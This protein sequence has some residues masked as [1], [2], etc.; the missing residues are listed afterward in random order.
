[1][2]SLR[3][4]SAKCDEISRCRY[5]MTEPSHQISITWASFRMAEAFVAYS[6]HLK[7]IVIGTRRLTKFWALVGGRTVSWERSPVSSGP[8]SMDITYCLP[9]PSYFPRVSSWWSNSKGA[10]FSDESSFSDN[11]E[12]SELIC[13][14]GSPGKFIPHS[15]E[16][17]QQKEEAKCDEAALSSSLLSYPKAIKIINNFE[18]SFQ[19]WTL[20]SYAPYHVWIATSISIVDGL[21]CKTSTDSLVYMA[22]KHVHVIEKKFTEFTKRVLLLF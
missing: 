13:T 17:G 11:K 9:V 10:S 22:R 16:E 19:V 8:R 20:P 1:M 15:S 4:F 6:H 14:L 3:V 12:S 18:R 7:K 2:W 21:S 5:F